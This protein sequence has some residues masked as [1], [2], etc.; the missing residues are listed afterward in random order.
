MAARASRP[1][2]NATSKR[3]MNEH[4]P[5][6]SHRATHDNPSLTS[7]HGQ[8][9]ANPIRQV[10]PKRS[11]KEEKDYLHTASSYS[12]AQQSHPGPHI[13]V[14]SNMY[15]QAYNPLP[16]PHQAPQQPVRSVYTCGGYPSY[17]ID[18]S[19]RLPTNP[20]NTSRYNFRNLLPS[21]IASF[22]A[23]T[24]DIPLPSIEG[25]IVNPLHTH[26]SL[27]HH[28]SG[29]RGYSRSP[30][31]PPP[32]EP[33]KKYLQQA[34]KN[35]TTSS[36]P[37][38]LLV[39]LDLNGTLLVRPNR[40]ADPK[41][42]VLRPGVARLLH[43]LFENHVVM[44]YSSARPENVQGIVSKLFSSQQ[45]ARIVAVWARD[46][47]D[48]TPHQYNN[49]VQ[50]YKKLDKIWSDKSIQMRAKRDHPWNSTN[51]VLVDDSHLKALAQPHNLVQLTEF[52]NNA[53]REGG[54]ALRNWQVEQERIMESLELRLEQLKWQVDVSR[55]IRRWQNG[56]VPAPGVVDETVDQKTRQAIQVP[57]LAGSPTPSV[58]QPRETDS[59]NT[60]CQN[61]YPTPPSQDVGKPT[62][63]SV[64]KTTAT[65]Q[66]ITAG[67]EGATIS[68]PALQRSESPIGEEVFQELLGNPKNKSKK[69]RSKRMRRAK[70]GKTATI[71]STPQ[72]MER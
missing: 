53:P 54:Q 26:R 69:A 41:S 55:L 3:P 8:T 12:L 72:S 68:D 40:K 49:K 21:Q 15:P 71:P 65:N 34:A 25:R 45:L 9:V 37:K 23:M 57:E 14:Q 5:S 28:A 17:R 42:F 66:D 27:P 20:A 59:D 16:L 52:E 48:L 30:A 1:S 10:D 38:K 11:Y 70:K 44:V 31:P 35:P 47:L 33:T 61:H 24:P 4:E 32:P 2:R 56:Q 51:T 7:H 22:G 63:R 62:E 36:T 18:K 64:N 46:K 13:P 43:Y 29:H 67:L 60:E 58:G 19:Y 50:V 6:G 39:I